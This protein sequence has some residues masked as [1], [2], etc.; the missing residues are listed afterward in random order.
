MSKKVIFVCE[1]CGSSN[2]DEQAWVSINGSKY[3]SSMDEPYYFCNDCEMEVNILN[4]KDYK[5]HKK[6]HKEDE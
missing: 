2:V 1:E 4:K 3:S 5:S 6:N